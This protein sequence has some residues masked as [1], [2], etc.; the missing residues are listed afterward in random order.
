MNP[1][2][3]SNPHAGF[4]TFLLAS[5]SFL[6]VIIL[7]AGCA[8]NDELTDLDGEEDT[9]LLNDH[10]DS[11]E[12]IMDILMTDGR[13]T[14]LTTAIDSADLITEVREERP[15]TIFAPTND[16]FEQL[17]DGTLDELL[18]D[19]DRLQEILQYHLVDMELRS[20]DFEDGDTFATKEGS[21]VTI[22]VDNGSFFVDEAELIERDIEAGNGLIHVVN[23]V[24]RPPND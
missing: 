16:A 23:E 14:T 13:F 4:T 11:G 18:Q 17:P 22:T 19:P 12:S 6:L 15:L 7:V 1:A 8:D 24:L 10:A 3:V 9:A 5:V 20:D 2:P 21:D